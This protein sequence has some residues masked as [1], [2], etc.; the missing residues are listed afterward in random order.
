MT[1]LFD[2]RQRRLNILIS[3]III[4]ALVLHHNGTHPVLLM[5]YLIL[6]GI[7]QYVVGSYKAFLIWTPVLLIILCPTITLV[8]NGAY[9]GNW[10]VL[11]GLMFLFL[12]IA[13]LLKLIDKLWRRHQL[14]RFGAQLNASGAW[15]GLYISRQWLHQSGLTESEQTFFKREMRTAYQQLTYLRQ[16]RREM[17]KYVAQY[18]ADLHLIDQIFQELLAAPRQLLEVS[19]F[20]Y[21]HLPDYV[22]L[23]RGIL[24]L[25]NNLL[26]T[27]SDTQNLKAAQQKFML[28]EQQLRS[29]YI[30]VTEQERRDLAKQVQ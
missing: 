10:F 6:A 13:G 8:L 2:Q 25:D 11:V 5:L 22:S 12:G 9:L 16:V 28:L 30:L 29:D 1:T 23:V 19:D 3:V 21:G 14:Q 17:I 7:L 15:E 18:E 4:G 26:Q 20:M 24:R 27:E